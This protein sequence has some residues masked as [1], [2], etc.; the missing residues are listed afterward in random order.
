[1]TAAAIAHIYRYPVKGLNPEQLEQVELTAGQALPED[2]RF[3]IAHGSTRIDPTNPGWKAKR[4]FLQLMENERLAALDCQ[5]DAA[6]G[7]LTIKR[8]GRQVARAQATDPMGRTILAQFFA[9]YIGAEV[10]G[11]PKLVEVPGVSFGDSERPVI[12]IVNLASVRD[13]ERVVGSAVDPLRFRAN[14]YIDGAE[15]WAERQWVGHEIAVGFARLKAID[16]IGRCAATNVDPKTAQRDLS[17]LKAL[18]RGFG[19]DCMGVYAEVAEGGAIAVGD[20]IN[21]KN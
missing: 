17:I 14:I 10:R 3:A 13:L 20:G 9:A 11:R 4:H 1:M 5:F 15:A 7:H 21:R 2:R 16:H 6:T 8:Q 19:H 18:A 12:S